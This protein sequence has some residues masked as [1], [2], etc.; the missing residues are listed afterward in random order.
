MTI[1]I[2]E[3]SGFSFDN[4]VNDPVINPSSIPDSSWVISSLTS[5][6]IIAGTQIQG[7]AFSITLNGSF[8]TQL[9][10]NVKNLADLENM[11]FDGTGTI[12]SQIFTVDGQ[13]AGSITSSTPILANIWS[14]A[15]TSSIAAQIMYSGKA[16]FNA[17]SGSTN[18]DRFYGYTG[19]ATF[20]DSHL[21][22]SANQDRFVGGTGGI[23]TLVL[24][25]NKSSYSI[26]TVNIWDSNAQANG[27]LSGLEL[28]DTSKT[29]ATVD[30][31]GVQRVQFKDT[32]LA[33][34][35]NGNAGT[36][37]KVLGAV[38]GSNFATNKQYVG[39]GLSLLDTGTSYSALMNL[40]LSVKLGSGFTD[41]QE[42]QL[43]YQNLYGHAATSKEVATI[44]YFITSGQY[45][46]ATLGVLAAETTNNAAKINLVGLAQTG[47]E[48]TPA[49]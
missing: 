5:S 8:N 49:N 48:F 45:T 11:S 40:A 29:F 13:N 24:P 18:G 26:S 4:S 15:G 3:A 20:N 7:H 17:P 21:Y 43:L 37:A 1:T 33:L 16:I 36:A 44:D 27:A 41:A 9:A 19:Y 10:S 28:K 31:S 39:I 32:S 23:N 46:Q 34:D 2:T 42:I 14:A 30:I 47:I 38:F 25:A 12:T 35:V 6:K 22:D